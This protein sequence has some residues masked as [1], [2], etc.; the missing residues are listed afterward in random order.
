D[1]I[2]TDVVLG[3]NTTE[4]LT[5]TNT[6]SG[7]AEVTLGEVAGDFE[8]HRAD[9]TTALMSEM[10]DAEGAPLQTIETEVS[11]AQH[12]TDASATA[13]PVQRGVAADPWT[14]LT[15]L[16]SVSMDARAVN[17][18]GTWYVIGGGSG[19][20]SYADVHRYDEADMA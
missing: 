17:L 15:P 2:T 1:S 12:A 19:A 18:D 13:D 8:I 3:E 6:G 14:D 9:G 11:F 4:E 16:G 5:I 7:T 10:H 20:T